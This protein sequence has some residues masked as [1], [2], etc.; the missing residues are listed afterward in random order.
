MISVISLP[1]KT[2]ET[3]PRNSDEDRSICFEKYV[4]E[5]ISVQNEIGSLK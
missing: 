2:T 5:V 3:I 1:K 4:N